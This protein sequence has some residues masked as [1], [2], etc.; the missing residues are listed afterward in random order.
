[1]EKKS[2]NRDEIIKIIGALLLGKSVWLII[3][4]LEEIQEGYKTGRTELLAYGR[5]K[6]INGLDIAKAS[7]E[8]QLALLRSLPA[9]GGEA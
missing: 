7:S 5:E 4:G 6:I 1:M 3:N 2:M 8:L 9:M